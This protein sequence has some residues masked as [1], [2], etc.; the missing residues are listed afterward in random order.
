MRKKMEWMKRQC[1]EEYEKMF[2]LSQ[3]NMMEDRLSWI[4]TS[5]EVKNWGMKVLELTALSEAQAKDEAEKDINSNK[6]IYPMKK[7][8]RKLSTT[9][10]TF[11]GSGS[12]RTGCVALSYKESLPP[13]IRAASNGDCD[14]LKQL[15]SSLLAKNG[16]VND[17]ICLRDR[18]ASTAEHWAAGG[19]YIECLKYLR[20]LKKEN[21][22]VSQEIETN[23]TRVKNKNMRRRDGKT[24][25]HYAA[26]NGHVN[27]LNFLIAESKYLT[28]D[29]KSG[30]GTTPLH[31]ACYGGKLK[32]IKLLID[33]G[34]DYKLA[35]TWGC[36][37]EHWIAM[38][39]NTNHEEVI[40]ACKFLYNE[41]KLSF[42]TI[43][44]QGHSPLHKAAQRKNLHIIKW[45]ESVLD[46]NGKSNCGGKDDGGNKPSDI[47]ESLGG[48]KK[49]VKWMRE[50]A[51][52]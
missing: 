12:D 37:C 50:V 41:C 31:M 48:D 5:E 3:Q 46:D 21:Q 28:V 7:K 16:N 52:W 44:K 34:A 8:R 25:L 49:F 26:R 1:Y 24:P 2:K 33:R 40:N 9:I 39:I 32:A 45:I 35:N 42:S 13:F 22:R 30:D 47:L 4:P 27:C 14:E 23:R 17:L 20:H 36:N 6:E 11:I 18:N 15:V 38:S 43:Q 19:G 51:N 10:P 29:L